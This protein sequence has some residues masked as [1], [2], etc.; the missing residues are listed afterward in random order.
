L[1]FL[2]QSDS[3]DPIHMDQRIEAFLVDFRHKLVQMSEP[4]FAA[5]VGALCQSFLEKNKNLSEESSRLTKLFSCAH[6]S[7]GQCMSVSH[8]PVDCDL[9]VPDER[10][11]EVCR[12]MRRRYLVAV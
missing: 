7:Y 1:L 8:V 11:I 12:L 2:I 4:D 10:S 3:F 6:V 5:S 9:L